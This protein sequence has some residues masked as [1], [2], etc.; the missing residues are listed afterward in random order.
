MSDLFPEVDH[1]AYQSAI[2][3]ISFLAVTTAILGALI[4]G[5]AAVFALLL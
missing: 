5:L 3:K 2:E 1:P 4:A